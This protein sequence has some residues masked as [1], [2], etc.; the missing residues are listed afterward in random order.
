M[1]S[2]CCVQTRRG[3]R[4][5][6]HS[7]SRASQA[8]AMRSWLDATFE[9]MFLKR[10]ALPRGTAQR[11]WSQ[12]LLCR[13]VFAQRETC[14]RQ[15]TFPPSQRSLV[16]LKDGFEPQL[17]EAGHRAAPIDIA[18]VPRACCGYERRPARQPSP[19]REKTGAFPTVPICIVDKFVSPLVSSRTRPIFNTR[20]CILFMR[21][22]TPSR[23]SAV[24][25]FMLQP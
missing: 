24:H 11:A 5:G 3:T 7:P 23:S 4:N 21:V 16:Q 12:E 18:S 1:C 22:L 20:S 14:A 17:C 9:S 6:D 19:G 15:P 10:L 25:G 8:S 13:I 2:H